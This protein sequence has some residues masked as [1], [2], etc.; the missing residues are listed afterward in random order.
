MD[1]PK[2][3]LDM[4]G[5]IRVT[6]Q[7]EHAIWPISMLRSPHA[8]WRDGILQ[9]KH[10]PLWRVRLYTKAGDLT[11]IDGLYTR[12]IESRSERLAAW[13]ELDGRR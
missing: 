8:S 13:I 4:P 3:P 7:R 9:L 2:D 12:R 6:L 11:R 10:S 5:A 1:P